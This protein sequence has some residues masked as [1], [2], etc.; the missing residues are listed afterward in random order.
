MAVCGIATIKE[1]RLFVHI[2]KNS[3]HMAFSSSHQHILDAELVVIVVCC[4]FA[5][6][7]VTIAGRCLVVTHFADECSSVFFTEPFEL[8]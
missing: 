4:P 7:R 5:A 1:R 3:N 8:F 6:V 2:L